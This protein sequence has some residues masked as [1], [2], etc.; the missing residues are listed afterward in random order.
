MRILALLACL[1]VVPASQAAAQQTPLLEP[2]ATGQFL[3]R[4]DF[5]FV[6]AGLADEDDRFSWDAHIGLDFDLVDY[7]VGRLSM[8]G[9][10]EV[11]MGNQLQPF[12][13]NQGNYTLEVAGSYRVGATEIAGMLHHVSRHLADRPKTQ[14]I[15]MNVVGGRALRR[16][17]LGRGTLDVRGEF[18]RVIERAY[19]DYSWVGRINLVARR[20]IAQHV[21]MFGRVSGDI[22]GVTRSIAGRGRQQGGRV[23]AGVRLLGRAGALEL[24]AG[25]ERV[26]DADPL[27][28]QP[29]RWA[30]GGFRVVN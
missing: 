26:V 23:E 13:P 11:V 29:R 21:G 25:F 5:H 17:S 4:H 28:R 1:L 14:A 15:A 9:D 22:Y 16:V 7:V 24:F 20:P 27:D 10:Y 18:G 12:D 6:M 19:L 3:S 8:F 30:F 2:P